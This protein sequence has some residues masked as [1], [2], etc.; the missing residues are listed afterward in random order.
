MHRFVCFGVLAL[1][2]GQFTGLCSERVSPGAKLV[3]DFE[4]R[5]DSY[6]KLR[7]QAAADVSPLK[8]GATPEAITQH[9]QEFAERIRALRPNARQGEIFSPPIVGEFRHLFAIALKG[10]DGRRIR[11]AWH[12]AETNKFPVRV[13]Q[14]YPL[15]VPLQSM[16]AA[17]LGNLPRLPEN[18]EY[19][20][21]GDDLILR[22]IGANL[23]VDFAKGV[24]Q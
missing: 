3:A 2:A 22:D 10:A 6:S 8:Q 19:R 24:S 20:M 18:L 4:Q 15:A 17:L 5:V 16:P 9:E 7:N 13:N 14:P 12:N 11:S 21:I 1:I 23:I